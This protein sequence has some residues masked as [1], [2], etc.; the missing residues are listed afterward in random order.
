MC[1]T[2]PPPPKIVILKKTAEGCQVTYVQT[3]LGTA[4]LNNLLN[5]T[6]L[7]ENFKWR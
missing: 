6:I 7:R 3:D 5:T 2:P 4:T 1:C